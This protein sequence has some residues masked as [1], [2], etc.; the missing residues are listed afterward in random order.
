[1][2]DVGLLS[3]KISQLQNYLAELR[4]SDDI[5][6]QE[7]QTD[8]RSKAFVERFIHLA[9]ESVIDIAN[10]IVSFQQWREPTGYRDLFLVLYEND[11]I[12]QNHLQ[13]FQN[14]AS[15]RNILVHRYN[16]IDD[17]VVFGIF[18]ERLGDFDLFGNLIKE[19]LS[20]Q[21]TTSTLA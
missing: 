3:R 14:M 21:Q 8:L 16:K 12:P 6:W 5:T 10:H 7:Y 11:V 9:I 1:M 18:Q 17:Q 4:K 20:N 15:F 2:I 19:W 13:T